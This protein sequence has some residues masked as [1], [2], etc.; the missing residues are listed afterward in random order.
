MENIQYPAPKQEY[1]VLVNCATYN[2]SKYIVDAL[3][4][5]AIQ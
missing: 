2:H 4:G 1:K 5:F 3:N